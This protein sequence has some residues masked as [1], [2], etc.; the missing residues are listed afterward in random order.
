[1]EP[2]ININELVGILK[3]Y[4]LWNKSRMECFALGNRN[5]FLCLKRR[6]FNVEDTRVTQPER[7]EKLLVFL[8]IAPT[9]CSVT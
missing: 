2:G 9:T 6:G 7:I 4:F 1:M 8:S 5:A 3:G